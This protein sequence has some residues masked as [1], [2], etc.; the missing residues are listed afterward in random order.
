MSGESVVHATISPCLHMLSD[1]RASVVLPVRCTYK[2]GVICPMYIQVWCYLSGICTSAALSVQCTYKCGV[3]CQMRI[4]VWCWLLDAH[5]SAMLPVGHTYKCSVTCQLYVVHTSVALPV[6]HAGMGIVCKNINFRCSET[7]FLRR[8]KT[9]HRE[10]KLGVQKTKTTTATKT[11]T[12]SADFSSTHVAV[13]HIL[14]AYI[15]GP[16]F[17]FRCDGSVHLS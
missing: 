15:A 2:C 9:F 3:G 16:N 4:Q 5:T 1:I 7:D 17:W 6:R 12:G 13:P 10:K 8:E 14:T 11:T